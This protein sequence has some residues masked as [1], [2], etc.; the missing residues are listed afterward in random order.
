MF[1]EERPV[2]QPRSK[3]IP[4]VWELY[5]EQDKPLNTD[6]I[7]ATLEPLAGTSFFKRLMQALSEAIPVKRPA[8]LDLYGAFYYR[9]LDAWHD[10]QRTDEAVRYVA[11][12]S[13]CSV[14]RE[15]VYAMDYLEADELLLREYRRDWLYH[16]YDH[17]HYAGSL[18]ASQFWL[19]KGGALRG[20]IGFSLVDYE[21]PAYSHNFFTTR[22]WP[23]A[24][25]TIPFL[26]IERGDPSPRLTRVNRCFAPA[27]HLCISVRTSRLSAHSHPS[28]QRRAALAATATGDDAAAP[29]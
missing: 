16:D 20:T 27:C 1:D 28:T 5:R 10:P 4:E 21:E 2:F 18:R 11:Q 15:N 19:Y 23:K 13:G 26:L 17:S 7:L 3:T 8:A 6:T 25:L 12:L 22:S 24:C 29:V 14:P 9:V